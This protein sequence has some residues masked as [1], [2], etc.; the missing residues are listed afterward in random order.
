MG[1]SPKLLDASGCANFGGAAFT[2]RLVEY[3][4]HVKFRQ[5]QNDVHGGKQLK[6]AIWNACEMAKA[7]LA[8]SNE[9]RFM[10]L[11]SF[12]FAYK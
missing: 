9:T 2:A 3:C 4:L 10:N 8:S 11:K 1:Q 12:T 6:K 5:Q 7:E